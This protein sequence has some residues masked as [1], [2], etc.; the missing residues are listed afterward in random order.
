MAT[1]SAR[2]R[3]S[4]TL[5]RGRRLRRRKMSPARRITRGLFL[6]FAGAL[7]L[8]PVYLSSG[9]PR[10]FATCELGSPAMMWLEAAVSPSIAVYG[11]LATVGAGM[12]LRPKMLQSAAVSFAVGF[13]VEVL[14][15][16]LNAGACRLRDM[17][18]VVVG[19]AMATAIHSAMRFATPSPPV[20]AKRRR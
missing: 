2:S 18:P 15:A 11:L 3:R 10:V 12:F 1:R 7:L 17:L 13:G 5:P 8:Y 20:K 14:E 9:M 4:R 19:I 6:A 16:I